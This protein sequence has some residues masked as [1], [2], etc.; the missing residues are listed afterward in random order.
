MKKQK[1]EKEAAIVLEKPKK[2][3]GLLGFVLGILFTLILGV[4][5][6]IFTYDSKDK[7]EVKENGE[8]Q[9]EQVKVEFDLIDEKDKILDETYRLFEFKKSVD[10]I[11]DLTYP[12]EEYIIKDSL[13]AGQKNYI[14]F[15]NYLEET[16]EEK[17]CKD[18][19]FADQ[20]NDGT[21]DGF[22][23]GEYH[24]DGSIVNTIVIKEEILK[25]YVEKIFGLNTY[26]AQM[27]YDGSACR[28]YYAKG[29]YFRQCAPMGGTDGGYEHIFSKA[30]KAGKLLII[31]EN[32]EPIGEFDSNK[33]LYTYVFELVDGNYIFYS[34]NKVINN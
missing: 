20:V 26:E 19:S 16:A 6:L 23:C 11:Y 29:E 34:L 5:V 10:I 22:S 4:V 15:V 30:Y 17:S 7:N 31:E 33:Y 18:Y 21:T 13:S 8:E 27:F 28:M 32:V 3:K 1:I 24:E 12:R 9:K 2:G 25:F 14:A